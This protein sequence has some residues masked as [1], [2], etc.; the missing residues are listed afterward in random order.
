V[1]DLATD[2]ALALDPARFAEAAG[3]PPDDWQTTVLRSAAPRMLLNCS[4]QSGKSTISALMALHAALYQQRSL[5]LLLAPSLR[6]SQELFRKVKDAARALPLPNRA[7]EEESALRIELVAGG[8]IVCL[9]GKE[10]TVRGFSAVSL[11]IVDEAAR[12]DDALYYAVRPMLAVSGGRL[13]LLSTPMGKRGFFFEEW[14]GA[15][16]WLRVEVKASDCPRIPA[17]FL[18]EERRALGPWY[19]QE[20]ACQFLDTQFQV[21][22]YESV[23]G[24][25]SDDVKPLFGGVDGAIY[26]RP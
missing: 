23:M 22:S 5:I 17:S 14:Q 9:P 24:A 10:Q 4:R 25:L 6:Q 11:L 19:E 12:V 26:A 16:E 8:R 15:A 21:F 13:I 20:Y 1:D 2:L 3:I 7:I 18:E